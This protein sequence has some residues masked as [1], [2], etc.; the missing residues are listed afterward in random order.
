MCFSS[1]IQLAKSDNYKQLGF[2]PVS[3]RGAMFNPVHWCQF[4]DYAA[5]IT[6]NEKENQLLLKCF[7]RWCQ[8]ANMIVR[9]DKCS[10]FGIKKF[11]IKSL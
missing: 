3:K 10:N 8:W 11:S 5:V 2:Y 1:F 7:T 6:T 4:T 9:V